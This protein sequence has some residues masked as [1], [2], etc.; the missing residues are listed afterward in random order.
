MSAEE[1]GRYLDLDGRVTDVSQLKQAIFKGACLSLLLLILLIQVFNL[2]KTVRI[3]EQKMYEGKGKHGCK[4][5]QLTSIDS[6]NNAKLQEL[7]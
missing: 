5:V 7:N 2:H 3:P 6:H 4:T 1:W